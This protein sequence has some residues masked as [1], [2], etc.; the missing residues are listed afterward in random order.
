MAAGNAGGNVVL[1][2]SALTNLTN[3]SKISALGQGA[4]GGHVELSGNVLN[5]RG[6]ATLGKGGHMLLDPGTMSISTGGNDSP[7]L[8]S[9]NT[10]IGHIGVG[11]IEG[12]LNAGD[13]V[14]ISAAN[15]IEHAG[16]VTAIT[17]TTGAGALGLKVGTNGRIQMEGVDI[18]IKGKLTATMGT[19]SFGHL[20][21]SSVDLYASHAIDLGRASGSHG[22]VTKQSVLATKG[23]VD[24]TAYGGIGS[25]E[26]G[27]ASGIAIKAKTGVNITGNIA[28]GNV[29]L[30]GQTVDDSGNINATGNVN[31]HASA[32]YANVGN[33][34]NSES[35]NIN[36]S[37]TG[38][39]LHA[40]SIN[41]YGGNVTITDT[42]GDVA[43]KS[44]NA[45][46]GN[47]S[48]SDA[49]HTLA[50]TNGSGGAHAG[51]NL[52]LSAKT[53]TE[54]SGN[55]LTL[56]AGNNLTVKGDISLESFFTISSQVIAHNL[57]LIAGNTGTIKLS[58]GV[59]VPG[60]INVSG[61]HLAYTGKG[62]FSM[63]A[64][65]GALTLDASIGS[66]TKTAN[67]N[68]NLLDKGYGIFLQR[69]IQLGASNNLTATE[70]GRGAAATSHEVSGVLVGDPSGKAVTLSAGGNIALSGWNV[71][72]GSVLSNH[73]S[74]Y[75]PVTIAAGGNVGMTAT[76]K[77]GSSNSG[78]NVSV[79]A[80]RASDAGSDHNN[81]ILITAGG[82]ISMTGP[83]VGIQGGL[84]TASNGTDNA[85]VTLKAAGK[86]NL[87][88]VTGSASI[89]Q[90]QVDVVGGQATA[91]ASDSQNAV[92]NAG[93][94]I[95][96]T[97]GVKLSGFK[98]FASGGVAAAGAS[99]ESG[100]VANATANAGLQINS[101]TGTITL[102][103]GSAEGGV[104]QVRGGGA[105]FNGHVGANGT[106]AKATVTAH[107]DVSLT[108]GG[109]INL[110]GY[111][112]NVSGGY[113]AGAQSFGPVPGNVAYADGEGAVATFTAT[114][115]LSLT[116]GAAGIGIT[117]VHDV[118]IHGEGDA[119]FNAAASGNE[120]GTVTATGSGLVTLLTT[121]NLNVTANSSDVIIEGGGSEAGRS[122]AHAGSYGGAA[123]NANGEVS[124]TAAAVTLDAKAGT[125]YISG[126]YGAAEAAHAS[127]GFNG[128]ASVSGL[129]DVAITTTTGALSITAEHE[130]SV[131]GGSNAAAGQVHN[132]ASTGTGFNS[133]GGS[134]YSINVHR[135]HPV[136]SYASATA[137]SHGAA[138]LT[139]KAGVALTAKTALTLS[140]AG[141][142]TYDRISIGGGSNAGAI[143]H[144]NA[145]SHATATLT[146]D[147]GVTMK[148]ATLK[149][150]GQDVYVYGARNGARGAAT[151]YGSNY[152]YH[153]TSTGGTFH[154]GTT[155]SISP[156]KVNHA[157]TGSKIS[158]NADT[159]VTLQAG[160]INLT[161]VNGNLSLSAG[162][163]GA[164][165]ARVTAGSGASAAINANASLTI[166]AKTAF[167]AT[168]QGS[169][170]VLVIKAASNIAEAAHVGASG[171]GG[172]AQINANG[173]VNITAPTVSLTAGHQI[174]LYGG[175]REGSY[176]SVTAQSSGAASVKAQEAITIAGAHGVTAAL[177]GSGSGGVIA[178]FAGSG[179]G[180]D[181]F[182]ETTDHGKA[183]LTGS[184]DVNVTA[185]GSGA[186]ISMLTGKHVG[187]TIYLNPGS[188]QGGEAS[189]TAYG[190]TATETLSGNVNVTAAGT[191]TI[192]AS[193][194][195]VGIGGSQYSVGSGNFGIGGNNGR[196][197]SVNAPGGT[198][199]SLIN[200]NVNVTAAAIAVKAG[201]FTVG[202]GTSA[203]ATDGNITVHTGL[204][205]DAS[206][207]EAHAGSHG[208]ASFTVN[209]QVAL[210]ATGKLTLTAGSSVDVGHNSNLPHNIGAAAQAG[211]EGSGAKASLNLNNSMLLQGTA[212][213]SIT[214]GD[215]ITLT[216]VS[217]EAFSFSPAVFTSA[218]A[219]AGGRGTAAYNVQDQFNIVTNGAFSMKAGDEAGLFAGDGANRGYA[220]AIGGGAT[221]T[222]TSDGSF[223]VTAGSVVISAG[224]DAWVGGGS[225]VAAAANVTVQRGGVA[226][227][228]TNRS[229]NVTA[230]TAIS[231]SLTGSGSR[232]YVFVGNSESDAVGL[233]AE[234]L[235]SSHGGKAKIS[236]NASTNLTVTGAGGTITLSAGTHKE[237]DILV[238]TG[239]VGELSVGSS[240]PRLAAAFAAVGGSASLNLA[241]NTNFSA[242]GAV[243]FAAGASGNLVIGPKGP[244][245]QD[246]QVFAS[247]GKATEIGQS[248]VNIAGGAVTFTGGNIVVTAASG[249]AHGTGPSSHFL[250][251][252]TA[253]N[254]GTANL[255]AQSGVKITATGAF[256]AT[257]GKNLG[258][259]ANG[260]HS[261]GSSGF[262]TDA[263][264]AADA[265]VTASHGANA[266]A[267]LTAT[268]AIQIN[269]ASI[270]LKATAGNLAIAAGSSDAESTQILAAGRNQKA[271]V[272][273]DNSVS[274]T[275]TG[276]FSARAGRVHNASSSTAGNIFIGAGSDAASDAQVFAGNRGAAKLSI[277]TGVN[278][279]AGGNLTFGAGGDLTI[280]G[281]GNTRPNVGAQ[282][283]GSASANVNAGVN[284]T[285][286]KAATLTAGGNV[287]LAGGGSIG[288]SHQEIFA[289]GGATTTFTANTAVS[290]VAGGNVTVTAA[291]NLGIFGGG[292][293]DLAPVASGGGAVTTNV[294]TGVTV[295]T[296]GNLSLTAGTGS[297]AVRAGGSVAYLADFAN[298]GSSG[299]GR[300]IKTTINTAVDVEAT[301][302]ATAVAG[303]NLLISAGDG[304]IVAVGKF[305]TASG[306]KVGTSWEG[307]SASVNGSFGATFKAGKNLTLTAGTTGTGSLA[308]DALQGFGSGASV[309]NAVSVRGG[310]SHAKAKLNVNGNALVQA[311]G[312]ITVSVADNMGVYAGSLEDARIDHMDGSATMIANANATL[313][314][315][316]NITFTKVGGD[317][318]VA[319]IGVNSSHAGGV[320]GEGAG[321][322]DSGGSI[323]VAV[324]ANALISAGG[325]IV[326]GK[327]AIGGDIA[328]LAAN[329]IVGFAVGPTAVVNTT[330]SGNAGIVAG[331][332]IT[333]AATGNIS[334]MGPGH[335]QAS[336]ASM[337]SSAQY[338]VKVQGKTTVSAGGALSLTAGGNLTVAAGDGV[339]VAVLGG[340]RGFVSAFGS[341][342]VST[343]L[344]AGG[345]MALNA[346]GN[347]W[348]RGGSD[349]DAH[350]EAFGGFNNYTG[351]ANANANITAGT[352]LTIVAGSGATFQGGSNA[353]G[354]A[355]AAGTA[356]NATANGHADL[357]ISVGGNLSIT[358]TGP[359]NVFGGPLVEGI[360]AASFAA[361]AFGSGNQAS[362]D[363]TAKVNITA[364]GTV[365]ITA[366]GGN[367]TVAGASSAASFR[368]VLAGSSS[369]NN[370]SNVAKL[371]A[372]G[373]VS[374]K[375]K[376]V[377]LTATG[378]NVD[379]SA[380]RQGIAHGSSGLSS[381]PGLSHANR[382]VA[383]SGG[384][385]GDNNTATL[386][387]NSSVNIT[388][389]SKLT[390]SGVAVNLHSASAATFSSSLRT[391]VYAAPGNTATATQISG[392]TLTAPTIHITPPTTLPGA[393]SFS[394]S[395]FKFSGGVVGAAALRGG[396]ANFGGV[397]NLSRG[398]NVL[399]SGQ[400][401]KVQT[402]PTASV[403]PVIKVDLGA[404]QE[405]GLVTHLV[406]VLGD[407]SIA[408]VPTADAFSVSVEQ[409]PALLAPQA[410]GFTPTDS[411]ASGASPA[412]TR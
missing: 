135:P 389:T 365:A 36:V 355:I 251:H 260:Y 16:G 383:A 277:N 13:A 75:G 70:T 298:V 133:I 81:S 57:N 208:S 328:I 80:G 120:G 102:A 258:I 183:T 403:A 227:L 3:S 233:G 296:G 18:T 341:A 152:V 306:A 269:A 182:V 122:R 330:V 254:G 322:S 262:S 156:A 72:V 271:T 274:L 15:L 373:S 230:K 391:V 200:D 187:A 155:Q 101:K 324:S 164:N 131:R 239:G 5:V 228:T 204:A 288:S 226:T 267:T 209:D 340:S 124:I 363:A 293:I 69:S 248:A 246:G 168:A 201:S 115:N 99:A 329:D 192:T 272:S 46:H 375:G 368:K 84:A 216:T 157:G 147:A 27:G 38:G 405:L 210:K 174:F 8:A 14:E 58:H 319:G 234:A 65:N 188:D 2:G 407:A 61:G 333:L 402:S 259:I 189:I 159:S 377:T 67:Y 300:A 107:A 364:A 25:A 325:S 39:D 357:N 149:V 291:E 185:L 49:G 32:G 140:Q 87:T 206:H 356:N 394:S 362:V 326:T 9:N 411:G 264:T 7:G 116:A 265:I 4:D 191:V 378:G 315:G 205:G 195:N 224:S 316:H 280:V 286:G 89:N 240:L 59:A 342:D 207:A 179:G 95:S 45:T 346:G 20:Q 128:K 367:L 235:A 221:A 83:R 336:V 111:R 118:E 114:N 94:S 339:T 359:V 154:T 303:T 160:T 145:S 268:D 86:V 166:K 1:K 317:F 284:M 297:I 55:S 88:A 287:V 167:T 35:G 33:I 31:V 177:S 178:L 381:A 119:L 318:T 376:N 196:S 143:A 369:S 370:Y 395:G 366:K 321:L 217:G 17:A 345:A 323:N 151:G 24:I 232:G 397:Q 387:A 279:K 10:S 68:V 199:T 285:A 190:G 388:A 161:A 169:N 108:A 79:V 43:L 244:V 175:N 344:H 23:A 53:I 278:I 148:A 125:V 310:S 302:S 338:S 335:V 63:S 410:T 117:G 304:V 311:G 384:P 146:G 42:S 257:A 142:S 71:G 238:R 85:T 126:G 219:I 194:G 163:S 74:N 121:G 349:A 253:A 393:S 19:G 282:S 170:G 198:A 358:A 97:K 299:A 263:L 382:L 276:N 106:D 412:G 250:T 353:S 380:G 82:N 223:N 385:S 153:H 343:T 379:I 47:V 290:L 137:N 165:T 184:G 350:V 41:A 371:T 12:Q 21:A 150:T 134:N 256:T 348:I 29:S 372:D 398:F 332:N 237:A 249:V 109:A 390:I 66:V 110:S 51:G 229:M 22:I 26:D 172:V 273:V 301:G 247:G 176:A 203:R 308:I 320:L 386:I 76:G 327:H 295:K 186:G 354:E 252:V 361:G 294:N 92:A 281:D 112:V 212:A 77:L 30:V 231:V 220:N 275:A 261:S 225:S 270:A 213:V 136:N 408:L 313:K 292:S 34:N 40:G 214:A 222:N 255:T 48:V 309:V 347:L 399:S 351:N 28:G 54:N 241:D 100:T 123:M 6:K 401:T 138:T 374:I 144:L 91:N 130:I 406:T 352:N 266:T 331:G 93:V 242:K 171:E 404:L 132:F 127:A 193:K 236:A 64:R 105:G 44:I 337:D 283:L 396:T 98:I 158:L 180:A 113:G 56:A 218:G 314:A 73:S 289:N 305:R 360:Q 181:A 162:W 307:G 139:G 334:I 312:S 60:A 11:F 141:S 90:G 37:A 173:Q 104:A 96:G 211:A 392:V 50:F 78:G 103:G 52:T 215:D 245:I 400:N 202:T 62:S 129:A 409:R 197:A 243:S